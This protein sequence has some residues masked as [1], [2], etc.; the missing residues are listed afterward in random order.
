MSYSFEAYRP[1]VLIAMKRKTW[2]MKTTT[3]KMKKT[4]V[5]VM[6]ARMKNQQ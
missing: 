3:A 6:K 1:S 2:L 4:K 5:L